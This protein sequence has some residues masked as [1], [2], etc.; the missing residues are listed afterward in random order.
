MGKRNVAQRFRCACPQQTADQ[1][2]V[3]FSTGWILSSLI[4]STVGFAIFLYGK[5]QTR[6]PQLVAGLVLMIFPGFVASAAWVWSIAAVI[7]CGL[8]LASRAGL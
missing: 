6:M 1:S 7:V 5:K 8:F 3:S 2:D 4:V